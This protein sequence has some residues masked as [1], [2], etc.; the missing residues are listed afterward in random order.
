MQTL[1]VAPEQVL[2]QFDISVKQNFEEALKE[3]LKA[4]MELKVKT[5]PAA[6][7]PLEER[8]Q[9]LVKAVE[10]ADNVRAL[11][12]IKSGPSTPTS[13]HSGGTHWT[14][15]TGVHAVELK[16]SEKKSGH[17]YY[18]QEPGHWMSDC[19][20]RLSHN[21]KSGNCLKC[22]KKGHWSKNCPKRQLRKSSNTSSA[23]QSSHKSDRS[24]GKSAYRVKSQ[25]EVAV[26]PGPVSHHHQ[27]H[28][29]GG[30]K[31]S[32]HR[33]PKRPDVHGKTQY[34]AKISEVC[35]TASEQ[36]EEVDSEE[37]ESGATQQ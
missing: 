11:T 9:L 7:I 21:Q 18:C 8:Y 5:D 33:K 6:K 10:I 4:E 2:D 36:I 14:K 20:K 25:H 24:T 19:K 29:V 1:Q 23:S 3:G 26:S 32:V 13:T 31:V 15:R 30:K 37:S 12:D 27:K 22:G 34:K 35:P 28:R 16:P 17:C